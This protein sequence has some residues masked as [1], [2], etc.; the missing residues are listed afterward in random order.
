MVAVR[1]TERTPEII[2]Q[3]VWNTHKLTR[4]DHV[5]LS[6]F[7]LSIVDLTPKQRE[8]VHHIFDELSLGKIQLVD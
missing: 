5:R 2:L 7:L 4:K 6:S 1:K 8:Q 3:Q